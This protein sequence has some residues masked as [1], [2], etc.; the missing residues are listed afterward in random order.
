MRPFSERMLDKL[1]EN[2][3]KIGEITISK[4][5][6]EIKELAKQLDNLLGIDCYNKRKIPLEVMLECY[7]WY[8][9]KAIQAAKESLDR[10]KPKSMTYSDFLH[11][12]SENKNW[13]NNLCIAHLI[14]HLY[15]TRNNDQPKHI[16]D[17]Y[18]IKFKHFA[19][20]L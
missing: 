3:S 13:I 18:S 5:T 19:M 8:M 16:R 1:K 20:M 15:L 14:D 4:A 10:I 17:L 7:S 2:P 12:L 9:I 11:S 6:P